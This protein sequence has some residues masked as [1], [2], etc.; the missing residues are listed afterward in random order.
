MEG[1]R[2]KISKLGGHGLSHIASVTVDC[3]QCYAKEKGEKM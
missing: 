3:C 2:G 1:P